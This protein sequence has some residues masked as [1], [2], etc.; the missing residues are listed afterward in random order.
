M[1]EQPF[2]LLRPFAEHLDVRL[3]TKTDQVDTDVRLEE[4]LKSNAIASLTQ[5]HGAR[6]VILRKTSLRNEEADGVATDATGLWL[7]IRSADCQTML[8]FAP[9][10]KVIGLLH[11][12]WKGLLAGAIPAFF[13]TLREE[14]QIHPSETI[15]CNAPSLCL[16]CAT[17]TDPLRELPGIDPRFFTGTQVDLRGIADD[18]L[19]RLGIPEHQRE[20]MSEC[21]RCS[22]ETFWSYR[23]EPEAIA[24]GMR[25]VLA[26]RLQT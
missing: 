23:A 5:V 15:V 9:E 25:N 2:S 1:I 19:N 4:L 3:C 20:R 26:C 22:K 21:T 16:S 11:V 18:A 13:D 17:F 10:Q 8:V 7:T 24:G 12:G 14:W 6:S